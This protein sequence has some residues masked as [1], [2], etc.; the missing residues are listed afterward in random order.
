MAKSRSKSSLG[1]QD[2]LMYTGFGAF[3]GGL[4]GLMLGAMIFIIL[5]IAAPPAALVAFPW[6][7]GGGTALG[8]AVGGAIGYRLYLE[9][10]ADSKKLKSETTAVVAKKPSTSSTT[11]TNQPQQQPKSDHNARRSTQNRLF[12]SAIE[13]QITN[14]AENQAPNRKNTPH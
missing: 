9:N 13:S 10:V 4:F 5:A 6:L 2:L 11:A 8:M 14:N 1:R 12:F 7:L 3:F